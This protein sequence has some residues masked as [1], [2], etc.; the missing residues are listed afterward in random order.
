MRSLFLQSNYYF[1]QDI[2]VSSQ[3]PQDTCNIGLSAFLWWSR[4]MAP[5]P[6][7]CEG[8][9]PVCLWTYVTSE[10][11]AMEHVSTIDRNMFCWSPRPLWVS[12]PYL[13]SQKPWELPPDQ[14]W[15]FTPPTPLATDQG[16]S[17]LILT[18]TGASSTTFSSWEDMLISVGGTKIKLT[19]AT[20]LFPNYLIRRVAVSQ[21][22]TK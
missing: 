20:L 15:P 5:N 12:V 1:F 21:R 9:W 13:G 6:G 3:C 8:C 11:Q 2:C 19:K 14:S 7:T 4:S 10:A 17:G 22:I 18:P 16:L